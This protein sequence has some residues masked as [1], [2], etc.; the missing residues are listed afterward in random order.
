MLGSDR[1]QTLARFAIRFMQQISTS[2]DVRPILDSALVGIMDSLRMNGGAVYLLDE[3]SEILVKIQGSG[4]DVFPNEL[5]AGERFCA[6][7]DFDKY[8]I[9]SS[10]DIEQLELMLEMFPTGGEKESILQLPLFAGSMSTQKIGTFLFW[11][12]EKIVLDTGEQEALSDLAAMI[13][14]GIEAL[15]GRQELKETKYISDFIVRVLTHE[16]ADIA[17][18]A[19]GSLE[20][21]A[22]NRQGLK[23]NAMYMQS[24][25][26]MIR[27]SALIRSMQRISRAVRLD[28][29]DFRPLD[30]HEAITRALEYV[31][32]GSEKEAEIQ[33][34]EIATP[35]LVLADELLV[36]LISIMVSNGITHNVNKKPHIWISVKE[37][38]DTATSQDCWLLT[39]TDD[40][41]GQTQGAKMPQFDIDSGSQWS[42]RSSLGFFLMEYIAQRYGWHIEVRPRLPEEPSKG[43]SVAIKAPM[44]QG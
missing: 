10:E 23:R 25:R 20:M 30:L 2:E 42:S 40:G 8:A 22:Y 41:V 18:M 4:V 28:G 1:K 33:Y 31:V 9:C 26:S 7:M 5:P 12:D 14:T 15:L 35:G 17:Q 16:I 43:S 11:A 38:F 27:I 36:D 21:L 3:L 6:G 37:T 13:G 39:V 32:A 24:H 29:V 44:Y 34:S 19:L